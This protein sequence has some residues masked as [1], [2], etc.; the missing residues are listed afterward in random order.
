MAS[1]LNV[2]Q[3]GHSTSGTTGLE[4]DTSGQVLLPAIPFMKM[5]VDGNTTLGSGTDTIH[6][7]PYDNILS[8]R[9]ITLNTSTYMFQV[10]VTGLY[11][12]S[13]AVRVNASPDYLWWAIADSGGT[14]LQTNAFVLANYRSPVSGFSTVTGSQLMP[15]TASTDYQIQFG[16]S[17]SGAIT[18]NAFQTWMDIFLVGGN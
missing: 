2:D 3:I 8:S 6:T 9:G 7:A 13:G 18:V 16:S 1:I 14:R 10:P 5:E 17:L 11:H 12:F 15:L 4:I